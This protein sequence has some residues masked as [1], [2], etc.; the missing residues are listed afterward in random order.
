MKVLV[1]GGLGF[2]GSHTVVALQQKGFEV[3]IVDNLSNSSIEVWSRIEHI[4]GIRPIFEQ[5]DLRDKASVH[6]LF[7]NIQTLMVSFTLRH[8]R[9][10]ARVLKIRFCITRT[11]SIP[12]FTCCKNFKRKTKPILYLV[13]PARFMV[14]LK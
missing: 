13:L 3:I 1:T 2:I 7:K 14:R 9:L 10:W 8:Q 6:S 4:T 12:L 5:M 11:T